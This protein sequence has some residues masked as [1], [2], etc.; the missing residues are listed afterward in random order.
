MKPEVSVI[1]PTYN[2]GAY[3][4]QALQSVFAQTYS[5]FEVILIDDASADSTVRIAHSFRDP[6]LRIIINEQNRGVSYGRN[7]GIQEARGK[8]VA[9]L[10][11]D[12]W[13]ATDR[14]EKLVAMGEA[15]NADLIADDLYLIDEGK[16][17][18]WSTLRAECSQ[19]NLPSIALIDAV[20][21]AT[22]DRLAAINAK[23]SWSLG[24]T[25]PL[26]RRDFLLTNQIRYDEDLKV[27]EDFTLYL[28]CLRRQAKFYLLEQ[29]YYYYRTREV[30][31]STRKPTE[32]LAE[33]C[34]I[35]QNFINR[36]A[37]GLKKSVL[38]ETLLENLRI[39][40]KRLAFYELLLS[41]RERKMDLALAQVVERPDLAT[42]LC[43]KSWTVL[44]KKIKRA[45]TSP[46]LE[47]SDKP[48]F[49]PDL[50]DLLQGLKQSKRA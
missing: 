31:L 4:T 18:H 40:Q 25:K 43:R 15:K 23:Q 9:L 22:S 21:F 34:A 38:L 28:E 27:G 3:I 46:A 24:Y 35:T 41:I 17:E 45:F 8:W 14:L 42:D 20:D 29:A 19:I 32:Y 10:D 50:R 13:Y 44:G 48:S 7:L 1:I 49:Y 11:S 16:R 30:S 5:N 37:Q 6:R 12:D 2:S 36:E 39:F 26:M 33:S 47:Q